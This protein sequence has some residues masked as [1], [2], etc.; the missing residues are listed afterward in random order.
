MKRVNK[1]TMKT[2]HYSSDRRMGRFEL[3]S[4]KQT[5]AEA[6]REEEIEEK[7]K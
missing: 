3:A 4:D 5:R 2:T 7:E 1:T 6:E